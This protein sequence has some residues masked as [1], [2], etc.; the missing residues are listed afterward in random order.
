MDSV[1]LA[2][3]ERRLDL[4]R[5]GVH[6]RVQEIGEGA[7]IVFV[8]GASNCGGSWAQLVA[9]LEGF[10]SVVLDRPGCGLSEPVSGGFDD[11]ARLGAFADD[12]IVD[13]LDALD[14]ERAHVASTSFGGFIA[15]HTAAA[16]PDRIDRLIEFGW[17]I[18]A[19]IASTPLVMRMASIRALGRMMTAIPPSEGMVRSVLKAAGLPR[20]LGQRNGVA[21]TGGLLSRAPSLH[22]HDAQRTQGRAADHDP[23][24][25][26]Q[27]QHPPAGRPAGVDRGADVLPL[28]RG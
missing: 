7:P 9:G 27:R 16:D 21:R 15:L 20:C 28:G 3:T 10:R 26:D 6:V 22:R 4:R 25:W 19:P 5:T 11:V 13:V 17:T 14:I 2:P 12:L 24:A 23:V 8:H 1:G 18:G